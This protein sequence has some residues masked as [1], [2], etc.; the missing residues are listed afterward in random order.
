MEF[1]GNYASCGLSPQTDGMPVIQKKETASGRIIPQPE[2]A[3]CRFRSR[4]SI[5]SLPEPGRG[6]AR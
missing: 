1:V 4:L 5:L 3:A 6:N 2:A